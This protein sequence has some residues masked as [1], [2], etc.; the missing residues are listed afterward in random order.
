MPKT[1]SRVPWTCPDCGR[2]YQLSP[3]RAL[4]EVCKQ[5][6]RRNERAERTAARAAGRGVP[7][8]PTPGAAATAAA[9][10]N[11]LRR[12]DELPSGG[13]SPLARKERDELLSHVA[14]ISRTMTFFRR[15]VWALVFLMIL[16]FIF[17]GVAFFYSMSQLSSLGGAFDQAANDAA[18]GPVDNVVNGR[19]AAGQQ[20][21]TQ[22]L[23]PALREKLKPVE[24]YY[25]AVND[26]LNELEGGGNGGA[27]QQQ[28][29]R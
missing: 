24:D 23:P 17:M 12:P 27:R 10:I 5:C 26:L 6:Q 7:E 22:Q 20:Q 28:P 9:P 16:N 14:N 2:D 1:K 25:G 18:V 21:Q 4:P 15:L 29:P 8:P 11:V 13:E 3:E 19:V